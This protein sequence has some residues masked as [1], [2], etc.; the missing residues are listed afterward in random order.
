MGA[1]PP[2]A[3]WT[4]HD[5]DEAPI[6]TAIS[7]I[8]NIYKYI[9]ISDISCNYNAVQRRYLNVLPDYVTFPGRW[10]TF[11]KLP[12]LVVR[13]Q[14]L[15]KSK[16]KNTNTDTTPRETSQE[17]TKTH[18]GKSIN[19]SSFLDQLHR[20]HQYQAQEDAKPTT[21][22]G[23]LLLHAASRSV[24]F[25]PGHSTPIRQPR[26]PIQSHRRTLFVH[27]NF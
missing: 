2:R 22:A 25:A 21:M 12:L 3:L 26:S 18:R 4:A 6:M 8:S 1:K 19:V 13:R 17:H 9:Y 27:H 16:E 23:H 10:T 24:R 14:T 15:S 7:D 11:T 5:S 20:F